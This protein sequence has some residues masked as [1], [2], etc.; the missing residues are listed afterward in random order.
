MVLPLPGS[1][2]R[3]VGERPSHNLAEVIKI[4]DGASRSSIRRRAHGLTVGRIALFDA[5]PA[6]DL[7]VLGSDRAGATEGGALRAK[8]SARPVRAEILRLNVRLKN[9]DGGSNR[10][11]KMAPT[12]VA[13]ASARS[14]GGDCRECD[15]EMAA[16]TI[17]AAIHA[18]EKPRP[19][20]IDDHQTR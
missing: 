13:S 18:R 9:R 8:I 7:D 2:G 4:D 15:L 5:G 14:E 11:H 19:R 12:L 1:C 17:L 6:S 20:R 10:A 16:C 3:A